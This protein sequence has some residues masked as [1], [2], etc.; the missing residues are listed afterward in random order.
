MA[1]THDSAPECPLPPRCG[2]T[3]VASNEFAL[4]LSTASEPDRAG[5]ESNGPVARRRQRSQRAEATRT[6]RRSGIGVPG[7]PTRCRPAML[8]VVLR[9]WLD[10]QYLAKTP[11][12]YRC[13]ANTGVKFPAT[14]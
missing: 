7:T 2:K 1:L 11:F 3:E 5:P 6:R 4:A 12:G 14:A 8:E 9:V 13:H 10:Q